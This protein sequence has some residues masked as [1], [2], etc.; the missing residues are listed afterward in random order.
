M[1]FLVNYN[2]PTHQRNYAHKL[3]TYKH[4]VLKL[5]SFITAG[6]YRSASGKSQNSGQL[7]NNSANGPMLIT[8]NRVITPVIVK[9]TRTWC[10]T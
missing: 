3:T 5:I 8:I 2:K 7:Q 1:W 4:F 10:N 9:L 6:N